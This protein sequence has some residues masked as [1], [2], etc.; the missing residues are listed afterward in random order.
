MRENEKNKEKGR[1][2]ERR[3]NL[4]P[5][6]NFPIL[7]RSLLDVSLICNLLLQLLN[8]LLKDRDG[9]SELSS[10]VTSLVVD[11]FT[12]MVQFFLLKA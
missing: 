1:R 8:P 5:V 3:Y 12:L 4:K 11:G 9:P 6:Q 7:T 2:G 10:H